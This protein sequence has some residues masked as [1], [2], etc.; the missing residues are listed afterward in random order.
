MSVLVAVLCGINAL[1]YAIAKDDYVRLLTHHP[2][3]KDTVTEIGMSPA[4]LARSIFIGCSIAAVFVL[5]AIAAAGATLAGK[6]A[7]RTAFV[8]L[9]FITL[10][11]SVI[12]FPIELVWTAAA[13]ATLVLLKRPDSRAWFARK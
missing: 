9:S 4:S 1:T 12:A 6:Q 11:T 3:M 10:P 2:L 13:I 5:A 7:G 8:V